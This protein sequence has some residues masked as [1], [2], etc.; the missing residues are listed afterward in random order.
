MLHICI[1]IINSI[2]NIT[3]GINIMIDINISLISVMNINILILPIA[4]C[5]WPIAYPLPLSRRASPA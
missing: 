5:L 3:N 4:Y 1:R 2:I